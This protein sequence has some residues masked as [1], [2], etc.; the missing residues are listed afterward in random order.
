MNERDS[1]SSRALARLAT[2]VPDVEPEPADDVDD[3][4]SPRPRGAVRPRRALA[5]PGRLTAGQIARHARALR[6]EPVPPEDPG[7]GVFPAPSPAPDAEPRARAD[8][9]D[10]LDRL[11]SPDLGRVAGPLVGTLGRLLPALGASDERRE[12]VHRRRREREER[13]RLEREEG[14][15]RAAEA[16]RRRAEETALREREYAERLQAARSAEEVEAER[17]RADDARRAERERHRQERLRE[18]RAES[19]AAA[20]DRARRVGEARELARAAELRAAEEEAHAHEREVAAVQERLEDEERRRQE[21]ADAAERRRKAAMLARRRR[22]EERRRRHRE[23]ER[24]RREAAEER[25]RRVREEAER[26][27]AERARREREATV[28]AER[29]RVQAERRARE[30]AEAAERER[31]RAAAQ[32]RTEAERRRVAAE[33]EARRLR[34]EA[35]RRRAEQEAAE[36]ERRRRAEE[37]ERRR[38][39][40]ELARQEAERARLAELARLRRHPAVAAERQLAVGLAVAERRRA[41]AERV[42]AAEAE[43]LRAHQARETRALM[44]AARELDGPERV[45]APDRRPALASPEEGLDDDALL[46]RARQVLPEWR[47][48]ER[49]ATKAAAVQAM[50]QG[51]RPAAGPPAP[52]FP[53]VPGYAPPSGPAEEVG[54]ATGR[55]RLAQLGVSAAFVLFVL[56]SAWGLGLAGF[57]PG[58]DALD[59]GSYRTAPE[60]RYRADATVLSLFFLHPAVWPVLWALLGL[61]VLHQWAPR[62]GAATRQRRTRWP[63]AAVLVLTAAWFPL[64][65][66][67]PWGLESVVWL[68]ALALMVVVLRRFTATPARTPAARLCT[69]GALGALAG[70]LLAAAPTTVAAALAA[71]GVAVPGLPAALPG[72]LAVAAVLLT[73]FRLALEDRGRAGLALGMSWTLMCLA[74]PRLLP[75]PVGS[76]TSAWVGLTAAFGALALLLAVLLR[77]TW[78]RELEEDTAASSDDAR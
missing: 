45:P 71:H 17:A 40:E 65:I 27:E 34:E 29:A 66:L 32:A 2:D 7:T 75:A 20:L 38:R 5:P 18:R 6:G 61:Y 43:A 42:A 73:G 35:E 19:Q 44:L 22:Q 28:A 50:S 41:E 46:A 56:A 74:L 63:V 24:A 21:R 77:R 47:R 12:A 33:Q 23:T 53:L 25:A 49:L 3:A 69:D 4:P 78:V 67:V 10:L 14:R 76:H 16:A 9:S 51:S 57:L 39:A 13:R 59:A 1:D 11:G 68:A 72:T 58:M 15:R 31:E 62:Q 64:A 30:E 26:R 54:R 8:L 70:L 52:A 36:A 60:G 55:D 37:E 48:R